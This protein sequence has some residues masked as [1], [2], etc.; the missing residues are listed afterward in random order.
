MS[1]WSQQRKLSIILTLVVIA[2]FV[3][4]GIVFV[5]FYNPPSCD[6]GVWNGSEAGVDCGGSCPDLCPVM[7]KQL[8][9]V[10]QRAFP[11]T[12]GVY[13]AVAYIENQNETFYVPAV[14]YEIE[15]YDVLNT[16]I[17]RVSEI[18]PIMPNGITPVFIPHILTG[19]QEVATASFR[20]VREPSF[21]EQP[22]PYG[23]EIKDIYKDITGD[24][25]PYVRATAVNTTAVA[26]P[27]VAFVIILYDEDGVAI[28]ASQTVEEDVRSGEERVIQF[29]WTF[30]FSL[31]KGPCPGGQ[32]VKQVGRVEIVPIILEW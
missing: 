29:S 1:A 11:L 19:Q 9:A 24:A 25:S 4:S 8:R 14:Q 3:I 27:K 28:A 22:Y 23:F 18:T 17:G 12:D 7:P 20:F 30:P 15:L 10:W 13:A 26:V 16:L 2:V 6:D 5:V 31:R 21:E 32:C